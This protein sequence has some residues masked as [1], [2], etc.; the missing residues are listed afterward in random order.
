MY[1]YK[2]TY[3][4]HKNIY[5]VQKSIVRTKTYIAYINL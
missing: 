4:I 1:Y 2:N 3:T 5:Y